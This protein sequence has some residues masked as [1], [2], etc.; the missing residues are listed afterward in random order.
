MNGQ[1]SGTSILGDRLHT[2][3]RNLGL[4]KQ[5]ASNNDCRDVSIQSA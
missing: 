5:T 4:S 3:Q 1:P 2:L